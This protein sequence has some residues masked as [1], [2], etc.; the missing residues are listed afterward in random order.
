[1]NKHLKELRSTLGITLEE[2][3]KKVGITRSAV[4]RLEKGERKLTEQM[5]I[6]IC[7]EF[8]VNE[9]WLRTG[10]GEMFNKMDSIDIAFNHF[11]YI[12][13]A[14][15]TQKKAVLSA[16]IEMVYCVPDDKWDYIIKQ[17]DNCLKESQAVKDS[18]EGLK[19][20]PQDT[21]H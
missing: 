5:I 18:G 8:N 17:F 3:G 1:M 16:L 11:G 4:G 20:P 15:T 7:R 9:D 13:S 10:D 12:M 21:Q 2:F 19:L 14:G 6:S